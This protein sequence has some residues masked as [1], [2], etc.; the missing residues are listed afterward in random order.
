MSLDI[1]SVA[2]KFYYGLLNS[3]LDLNLTKMLSANHPDLTIS[4]N[5]ESRQDPNQD[6]AVSGCR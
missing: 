2:E 4:Y 6:P 3:I 1:N 5:N